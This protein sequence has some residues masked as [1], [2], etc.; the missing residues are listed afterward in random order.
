MSEVMPTSRATMLAATVAGFS[1]GRMFGN[2][3]APGLFGIGFWVTCL[4]A[5]VLNM[6]AAGM[7]TQVRVEN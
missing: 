5:V 1:L 6:M 4:A 7:L 2:L 3:I